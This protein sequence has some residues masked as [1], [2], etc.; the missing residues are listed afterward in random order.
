MSRIDYNSL[1]QWRI[2]KILMI[3]SSYDAY[4]LEEDGRIE[5][6]IF[7]EYVDL[8]LSNPPTFT[9]V[10]TAEQALELLKEGSEF[11]LIISMFNIGQVN[12]FALSREVKSLNPKIP[13]VLLTQFS[14]EVQSQIESEDCSSIDFIFSWHGNADLILAIIKLL[15]DRKNA[16][17][18][19]I[20]TGVQAILL[21]EDSIRYYSTYLPTIYKLVL[22]QSA[23]FLKEALNEQQQKLRKRAR[24][25]ILLATNLS[26]AMELYSQYKENLLGVISDVAFV[27]NKGDS[28]QLE[29][30]DAGLELCRLIKRDDPHM[31]F[32]LQSSQE[33]VREEADKMGVGFVDKYSKTLLLQLSQYISEEF[34]FGDFVFRDLSTGDLLGRA[35]DLKE[36]QQLLADVPEEVLLFHASKN[37]LSKWMFSRGLFSLATKIRGVHQE[38][39]KNTEQL[40]KH[41]IEAI[42]EYRILLGHGVVARFEK[43]NYSKYIWFARVGEG[44]LGGKARGIAFINSILQ[45]YQLLDKYDGV[46][47]VIPRTIVIAT[48]YFDEF[49][50]TNGLQ[51]VIDS[52]ISDEEI[53][54][55]FISSRLPESLVEE[56]RAYILT[57]NSPLAVRSSSKLEDSHHQPFAGVYSTYMIP[58]TQ[59]KDQMLRLLGKAIKSVYASIYFTSSRSYLT[60]TAN[61]L[62][63]EKM[64]VVVQ[65]LV[66]T[67]E[68]GFFF[69]TISGVARSINHYPIGPEKPQD[70]IANIVYG[71]G[72]QVVE[73]GRSLRF[74]PSYPKHAL[75]LSSTQLTLKGAQNYMYALDLKP[76]EF[77]TS[78]DDSINL[79]RFDT[80]EA[81]IFST[82]PLVASTWDLQSE[83]IIDNYSEEG[84]KVITFAN[85]IKH[86][87]FPLANILKELLD[88]FHNE[89]NSAVEMEFAVNIDQ[90]KGDKIQ[91]NL[92]QIRPISNVDQGEA[93]NWDEI[94]K[95]Q[96]IIYA[97]QALGRGAIENVSD[98]IY[99]KSDSFDSS[100]S[101]EI[102]AEIGQINEKMLKENRGYV[103]VGPGRW[104]SSDPWLGIPIKWPNISQAKVIVECGL[105]NYR[106]EPSQGT[107]FFQNLTS[108]GVGYLTIN[109]YMGDGVFN[110]QLLNSLD[111]YSEFRYTRHI[112]F[113]KPLNIYIDGKN[114][115]GVVME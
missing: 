4:T 40:R 59:N 104:G 110:E 111:P 16:E 43:E 107:H 48:D 87:S 14:N 99:V 97:Q 65:D 57:S 35:K 32:L 54:S 2:E 61:V 67:Q 105:K 30:E 58:S 78:V 10:T 60:A 33:S 9:W 1:M 19:I 17:T 52:E 114:N 83:S 21:V 29:K 88:I 11:D 5:V 77:K 98:I 31:P 8:D 24:P 101:W 12:P 90:N 46:N 113:A 23:E 56:L 20:A 42:K 70:G 44:S 103:L 76:E 22:Q 72:K 109:P 94:E 27:V 34:L 102:A 36:M 91:F 106:I 3:C 66:G 86:E 18:D 41:I 50:K 69:P 92:L 96:A 15:E 47:I 26:E 64:A 89:M 82:L 108:F 68:S 71:L 75:Q 13:F 79:K 38:Q 6:Q 80:S 63:E 37:R 95:E 74:S 85:I 81:K 7:K 55:E 73:G 53:L 39:F 62:S 51:Y 49:I 25:K 84:P 115:R 45:K 100:K 93:P 28:R 112:R